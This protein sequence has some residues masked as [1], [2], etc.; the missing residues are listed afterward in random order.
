MSTKLRR[1]VTAGVIGLIAVSGSTLIS[2][3]VASAATPLFSNFNP[4]AVT[5]SSPEPPAYTLFTLN[6][7]ERI[8][9]I[10]TYHWAGTASPGLI[11]IQYPY[12]GGRN[13]A[14]AQAEGTPGQFGVANANWTATFNVVLPAGQW[15]VWDTSPDTWSYNAQSGDA[16][17]AQVNGTPVILAPPASPRPAPVAP[18]P[19]PVP[20]RPAPTPPPAIRPCY[21]NAGLALELGPC[22]GPRGTLISVRVVAKLHSPLVKVRFTNGQAIVDVRGLMGGG[23]TAGSTYTFPAPAQ[24]CLAGHGQDVWQAWGW[25]AA[26]LRVPKY[27]LYGDEGNFGSFRIIGC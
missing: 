25:D 18:R 6:Q 12:S 19:A 27:S 8:T 26:G 1:L 16:G 14:A 23:L 3:A 11:F 10:S 17:F 4:Y 7:P 15:Q 24:L 20:P 22:F 13:E 9:S 21:H 2:N 5:Q